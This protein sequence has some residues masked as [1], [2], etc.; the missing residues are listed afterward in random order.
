[1]LKLSKK[2]DYGL[3]SLMHLAQR[4]ERASWSA[5]EIAE[6]YDIP[7]ELLSKILQKLVQKG[8]L[9]SHAGTHGGYSLG[10]AAGRISAAEVIEAIEGPLYLTNCVSD[11]GLCGQ[12][13]KCNVKSPLQRLNDVVIRTFR[14][15]TIEEMS[16]QQNVD[17][18]TSL[19][20][21]SRLVSISTFGQDV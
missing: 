17:L 3:M 11:D 20:A 2:V 8:L 15:L 5:R 7:L 18:R 19:I 6:N 9:I 13:E 4:T 12:F 14:N 10:R 21:E 16:Q 1:M